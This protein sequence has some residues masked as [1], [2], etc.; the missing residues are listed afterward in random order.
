MIK[1]KDILR[2]VAIKSIGKWEDVD[3]AEIDPK[4][5]EEIFDLYSAVYKAEGLDLSVSSGEEMRADYKALK[6]KDVDGDSQADCFIIYK[7]VPGYGNKIALLFTNRKPGAG[8]E[9]IE[10]VVE[11][12]KTGGWFIEAS[13]KVEKKLAGQAPVIY[14]E[15]TIKGI[16]GPSK[17]ET[18][19]FLGDGYYERELGAVP[20][21]F[22]TKR[23]YGIPS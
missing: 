4:T 14:D 15:E 10:K 1:L 9:V 13:V 20:G 7:P 16:I 21:K 23:L 6:M 17:A 22:I 11:L 12:C 18:I 3:M 5:M 2:E 19:K 8:A